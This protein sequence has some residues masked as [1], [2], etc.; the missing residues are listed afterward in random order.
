LK[1]ARGNITKFG[2][3]KSVRLT[4]YNL[5]NKKP[6]LDCGGASGLVTGAVFKTVGR[7]RERAPVG[8]DSH[9]PP[10]PFFVSIQNQRKLQAN[11]RS[12]KPGGLIHEAI[13]A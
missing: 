3:E 10:P 11:S 8:F 1:F 9:T 2:V 6:A 13:F 4:D 5:C 7:A 12:G